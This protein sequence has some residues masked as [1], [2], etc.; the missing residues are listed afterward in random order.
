MTPVSLIRLNSNLSHVRHDLGGVG[1]PPGVGGVEDQP[2]D[3]L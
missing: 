2:W 1:S 3:S